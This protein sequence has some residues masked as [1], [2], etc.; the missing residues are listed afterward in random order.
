MRLLLLMLLSGSI[1]AESVWTDD[2][3]L[4]VT[5]SPSQVYIEDGEVKYNVDVS[6]DESSFIYGENELTVCQPTNQGVVC[7]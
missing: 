1:N 2:G 6:N 7:Y 5:D 4:I 3:S